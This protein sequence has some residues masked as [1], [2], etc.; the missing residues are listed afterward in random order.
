[1]I[2]VLG[3]SG[4]LGS[5]LRTLWRRNDVIWSRRS[6]GAGWFACDLMTGPLPE[7]GGLQ[8][9]VV[10]CLAGVVPGPGADLDMNAGIA[11]RACELARANGAR[12]VFLASSAAIYGSAALT[13]PPF[14]EDTLP[15]PVSAYGAAK[16]AAEHAVAQ[17]QAHN[18][19]MGV[20]HLR[21]GNVA[22]A[23]AVLG[24]PLDARRLVDPVA[25]STGGPLRSYIG[26]QGFAQVLSGLSNLALTGGEIPP[27]LNISAPSPVTMGALLTA[28]GVDWTAGPVNPSVI[29]SVVLGTGRLERLLPGQAG[30]GIAADLV[31]EWRAWRGRQ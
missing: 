2:C 23:D 6:Q 19:G 20:T 13:D 14:A 29:P 5:I 4:R 8:G 30:T 25:G 22:G 7:M 17:W 11:V 1:M 31:T 15:Q 3:A 10:L 21:I 9:G 24:R 16:L 28:A 27:I 26:P 12:H 18:A